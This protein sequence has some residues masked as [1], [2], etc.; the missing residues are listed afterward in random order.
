MTSSSGNFLLKS[1]AG[2]LYSLGWGYD[3]AEDATVKN[4]NV[5]VISASGY[6]FTSGGFTDYKIESGSTVT[7]QLLPDYGYQYVSG[8][9]N[10][11]QTA[12]EKDKGSY[13]FTMPSNNLHLSAIFEK[14]SDIIN[15]NSGT[16]TGATIS[17]PTGDI[18]GNAKLTVG[19]ATN[20]DK[21]AFE[22]AAGAAEIGSYLSMSLDEIIYKGTSK[23]AW[24]TNITDLDKEMTVKLSL[25]KSLQ[26]HANYTILCN[27]NGIMTKI[28]ATYDASTNVLSFSTDKYST[29]AIVYDG[30]NPN[31]SGG[32]GKYQSVGLAS[33]AGLFGV[34][35]Y[36]GRRRENY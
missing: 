3:D 14:S 7:I 30:T 25:A 33:A 12:P 28:S 26:G 29:Y 21:T 9:L 20:V 23:E 36:V 16:V 22:K 34:A 27:H 4:G 24:V 2:T 13:T 11:N 1:T 19:D 18:N 35:L 8:G 17:V 31:T 10:G 32:I 15:V 6:K 5:N